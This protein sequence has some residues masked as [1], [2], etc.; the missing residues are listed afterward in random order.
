MTA[1]AWNQKT[2]AEFKAKKGLGV[3]AWKDNLL[4]MTAKGVKSGEEI[5]T[6][7]VYKKI[8]RAHV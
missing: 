4:L 5:T 6:P 2:I 7:L 8:G 3:G 1:S